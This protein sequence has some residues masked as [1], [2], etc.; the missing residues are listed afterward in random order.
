MTERVRK[1]DASA[2]GGNLKKTSNRSL[3]SK[4]KN[5]EKMSCSS[6]LL[7]T[8][9]FKKSN[10]RTNDETN[11]IN[12]KYVH[13][14]QQ[15]ASKNNKKDNVKITKTETKSK[16]EQSHHIKKISTKGKTL[17]DNEIIPWYP[18][19]NIENQVKN[20]SSTTDKEKVNQDTNI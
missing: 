16:G 1:K 20:R 12:V 15:K 4:Q 19:N 3:W 2:Q 14:S 10:K 6:S 9:K 7:K 5:E 17:I 8:K 13:G 18:K 11:S